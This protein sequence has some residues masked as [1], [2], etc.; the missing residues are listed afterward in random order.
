MD[1]G[2]HDAT[3]WYAAAAIT[4]LVC[5][6]AIRFASLDHSLF[7]DEVWVARLLVRGG[8]RPH[9]YAV[10]PLFYG[11]GRLWTAMRGASDVA[12]REPA[13][14]FG[15]VLCAIPFLAP[16]PRLTRFLWSA[17]LAFSSPL[18]FY[19]ERLKQYTLE[20][21][22]GTLLVVLYLRAAEGKRA[23]QWVLFFGVAAAGV[24]TL[25]TPVFVAAAI[26]VAA[27]LKPPFGRVRV[28]IAFGFIGALAAGAYLAYMSPGPETAGLHGDMNVWFTQTG[29]WVTSPALLLSNTKHWIG[30]ALNL[31]PWAL[32]VVLALGILWIAIER[33]VVTV[34]LAL[35]PPV[36]AAIASTAHV[37]PYGEV[38]LMLYCF[39]TLY[40]A[41]SRMLTTF[42]KRIP[43]GAL[44]AIPFVVSGVV[45]D[46]Y[47]TTYMRLPDLRAMFALVARTPA[48]ESVYADASYA[49][50]LLYYYPALA[51]RTRVVTLTAPVGPG[52]Y[53]QRQAGFK[54]G[55][56]VVLQE[57]GVVAVR[58]P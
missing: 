48:T 9:T 5:A 50:P 37:Y 12:L 54:G 8:L 52:W 2:R 38:R 11:I 53:V 23:S 39:P 55:G 28:V 24:L 46:P 51:G 3:P 31:T 40:L 16:L 13:A 18:I 35:V 17:L 44:L 6:A 56:S 4:L 30:Q 7:E 34:A 1:D 14:A 22:V 45:R 33:D 27:L 29:R 43:A 42:S 36:I 25:H 20:A 57:D 10:P 32:W 47:A 19:S 15:V 58:V 26:G 21:S 49:A 41:V